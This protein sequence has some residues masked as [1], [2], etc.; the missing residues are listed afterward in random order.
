LWRI[1]QATGVF[2]ETVRQ[3]ALT[4]ERGILAAGI[5]QRGIRAAR[6]TPYALKIT[7]INA[8]RSLHHLFMSGWATVQGTIT[9]EVAAL[10]PA[11]SA[12]MAFPSV[13]AFLYRLDGDKA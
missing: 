11:M 10:S 12:P 3:Q 2:R 5:K 6:R 9:E 7:A 4:A 13:P 8:E 1:E